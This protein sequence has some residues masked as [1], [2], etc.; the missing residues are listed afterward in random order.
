[1]FGSGREG[2]SWHGDPGQVGLGEETVDLA[3]VEAAAA[4][5][6]GQIE[7]TPAYPATERAWMDGE[8]AVFVGERGD[9]G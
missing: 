8:R 5:L 4:V 7:R 3:A 2:S 6:A 9:F 1:M